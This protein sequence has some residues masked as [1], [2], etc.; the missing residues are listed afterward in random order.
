M[1]KLKQQ[2]VEYTTLQIPDSPKP[3]Q[4]YTDASGYV[5]GAVLQ[6]NT[7]AVGLHSQ[8]MTP[9]QQKCCIYG[10]ELLALVT[11]LDRWRHVLFTSKVTDIHGP[12]GADPPA[13][14]PQEQAA[15]GPHRTLAGLPS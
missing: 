5:I 13:E 4:L 1:R 11:A 9:A 14:H 10:Q 12:P 8:G 2:L 15:E 7:N 6:R 3:Y